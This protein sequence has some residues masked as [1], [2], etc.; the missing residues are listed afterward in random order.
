MLIW[1]QKSGESGKGSR[2]SDFVVDAS[3]DPGMSLPG[4]ISSCWANLQ[5]IHK[6]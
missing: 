1:S 2:G 3:Q 6:S 5:D 4:I